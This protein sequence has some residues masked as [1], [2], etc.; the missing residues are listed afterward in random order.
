MTRMSG[1]DVAGPT[2]THIIV[3]SFK[4]NQHTNKIVQINKITSSIALIQ[5]VRRKDNNRW[6]HP[7]YRR[8][9]LGLAEGQV[10]AIYETHELKLQSSGKKYNQLWQTRDT[11]EKY[12]MTNQNRERASYRFEMAYSLSESKKD[13]DLENIIHTINKPAK[14]GRFIIINESNKQIFNTYS[15]GANGKFQMLRQPSTPTC[16][17]E[18]FSIACRH[19]QGQLHFMLYPKHNPITL[20]IDIDIDRWLSYDEIPNTLLFVQRRRLVF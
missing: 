6:S 20:P 5:Q 17:P 18:Q 8:M 11:Q 10:F 3:P 16:M 13:F 14:V 19:I 4:N 9:I 7:H 2:F 12:M 1:I 15:G